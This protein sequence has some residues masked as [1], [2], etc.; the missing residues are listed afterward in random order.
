[1]ENKT[2][3][4]MMVYSQADGVDSD[5]GAEIWLDKETGISYL[6]YYVGYEECF[7]PLSDEKSRS[8]LK[9]LSKKSQG[10]FSWDEKK[11]G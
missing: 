4:Y 2:K 6:F 10:N 8:I 5:T 11:A 9:H 7:M 1:M 3:R